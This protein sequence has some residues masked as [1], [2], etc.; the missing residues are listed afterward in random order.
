MKEL[1]GQVN[2][3]VIEEGTRSMIKNPLFNSRHEGYAVMLEE[4]DESVEEVEEVQNQ[5]KHMWKN[6]K[7]DFGMASLERNAQIIKNHAILLAAESIQVAAMAQKFID[8]FKV[9]NE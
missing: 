1:V 2:K 7:S 5:M 8:S 3:L 9:E 6:I 4:V